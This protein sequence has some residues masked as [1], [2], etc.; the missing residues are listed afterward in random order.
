MKF[1]GLHN[2]KACESTSQSADRVASRVMNADRHLPG[3]NTADVLEVFTRNC[4]EDLPTYT[5]W[6]D[7]FMGDECCQ[8]IS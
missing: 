7:G 1:K 6:L 8:V 2:E 4:W 3:F 5:Y